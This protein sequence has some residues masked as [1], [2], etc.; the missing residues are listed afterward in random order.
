MD[1]PP[2][3]PSACRLCETPLATGTERCPSC[4]QYQLTE[5]PAASRWRLAGGLAV[6]YAVVA[7]LLA[8]TK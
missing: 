7:V 2:P 6:I 8:L 3:A 5:I 1:S 4:G